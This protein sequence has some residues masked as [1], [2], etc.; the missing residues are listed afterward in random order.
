MVKLTK[1]QREAVFRVYQ[2]DWPSRVTPF[3]AHNGPYCERCG[4]GHGTHRV[5][6]ITYRQFRAKVVGM[7]GE[8]GEKRPRHAA[9]ARHVARHRA[10]W[11]H[12]QLGLKSESRPV[13]PTRL[14]YR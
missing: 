14:S 8:Y 1:A 9:V 4:W 7:F 3:Q 5:P 11:S 12:P 10:R 2:R 6:S 13:A